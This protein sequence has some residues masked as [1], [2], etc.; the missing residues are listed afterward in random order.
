MASYWY[1]WKLYHDISDLLLKLLIASPNL[2]KEAGELVLEEDCR[3]LE[4][5]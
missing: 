3:K 4:Q 5:W 1:A 2:K